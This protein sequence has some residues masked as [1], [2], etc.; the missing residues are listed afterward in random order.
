MLNLFTRKPPMAGIA[1]RR[2]EAV[3]LANADRAAA[4]LMLSEAIAAMS[5]HPDIL[6]NDLPMCLVEHG[7]TPQDMQKLGATIDRIGHMKERN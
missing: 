5:R 2:S 3:Q 7:I 4:T 1:D 6:L